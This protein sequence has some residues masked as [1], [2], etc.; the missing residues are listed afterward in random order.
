METIIITVT[1]KVQGGG[2]RYTTFMIAES[3]NLNGTVKNSKNG[4]VV[5]YLQGLNQQ[6]TKFIEQL[7]NFPNPYAQINKINTKVI[8]NTKKFNKFQIIQ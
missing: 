8:K 2:F 1:G 4:K 7:Q 5:I 6:I 3:L